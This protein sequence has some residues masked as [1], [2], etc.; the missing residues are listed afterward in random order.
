MSTFEY[1]S[2]GVYLKCLRIKAGY[3]LQQVSENLGVSSSYLSAVE[4]DKRLPSNKLLNRLIVLYG[5]TKL[6]QQALV[7]IRARMDKQIVIHTDDPEL[8]ELSILFAI[9]L[10]TM[11]DTVRKQIS[12]IL[13]N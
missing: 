8:L 13:D 11:S 12:D 7:E 2:I 6:E 3:Q 1:S 10:P 4:H 5:M 9:R